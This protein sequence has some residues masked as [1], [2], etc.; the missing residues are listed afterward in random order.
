M[1]L[2]IGLDDEQAHSGAQETIGAAA[3]T[4]HQYTSFKSVQHM[5]KAIQNFYF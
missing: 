2:K 3:L 1:E 5:L 4:D